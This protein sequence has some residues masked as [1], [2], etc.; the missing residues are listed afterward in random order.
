MVFFNLVQKSN[1][2]I[3]YLIDKYFGNNAA[4]VS[5]QLSKE[6]LS[7]DDN[8]KSKAGRLHKNLRDL[9]IRIDRLEARIA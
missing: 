4:F 3:I 7:T 1:L 6:I 8:M 2:D 9:H 5:S